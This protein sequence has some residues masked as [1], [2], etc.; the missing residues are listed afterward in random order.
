MV[1]RVQRNFIL[2]TMGILLVI[3]TAMFFISRSILIGQNKI[4]I[5]TTLKDTYQTYIQTDQSNIISPFVK[6]DTFFIKTSKADKND[7]LMAY[8][9]Q[10]FTQTKIDNFIAYANSQNIDNGNI[11]T[12]YYK[13][14]TTDTHT[15]IVGADMNESLTMLTRLTIRT[16]IIF[17]IVYLLLFIVVFVAS[18]YVIKPIKKTIAS[19]R[20]FI[21]NVSHELKTPLT[22]ISTNAQVLASVEDSKW[23]SNIKNQTERMEV[24]VS[25]MLT[26]AKFDEDRVPLNVQEFNLSTAIVSTALSFDALAFE[27]GKNLIIEVPDDVNYVGDV[28]SVKKIVN[29]LLD[30]AIKHSANNANII[31]TLKTEPKPVLT[32]YNDGSQVDGKDEDKI[33]DRFFRGDN[34]RARSSGGSGLGLAIAKGLAQNN[35]WK[36][37]A[38]SILNKSMTITVIL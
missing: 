34:S 13:I 31:V 30:N 14:Y 25:D 2:L 5:D 4:N 35:K 15:I 17:I 23:V 36:I 22:I 18:L 10:R 38:K 11:D 12:V 9:T 29:I 16:L 8:D 7:V 6:E 28:D 37:S 26:L 32:V 20:Q 19:Q 33:F 3:F 24:L 1:K 27:K 21:S